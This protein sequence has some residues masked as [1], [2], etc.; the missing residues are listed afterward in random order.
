MDELKKS[1]YKGWGT[2]QKNYS[3]FQKGFNNTEED[4]EEE[5]RR[6]LDEEYKKKMGYTKPNTFEK[7][8][9]YFG[10]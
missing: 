2:N 7:L 3:N 8:K 1:K 5:R 9:K 6:K 10:G 4:P